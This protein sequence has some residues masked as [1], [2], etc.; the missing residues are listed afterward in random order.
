ML[1][2]SGLFRQWALNENKF[3]PEQR[4]ELIAFSADLEEL[5]QWAGEGWRASDPSLDA[6]FLRF[7]ARWVL[8]RSCVIKL[9]HTKHWLVSR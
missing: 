5:A 1:A 7:L 9:E 8:D 2:L 3:K 4:T 6:P